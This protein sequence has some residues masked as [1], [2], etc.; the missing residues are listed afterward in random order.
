M[1]LSEMSQRVTSRPSHSAP[2]LRT[3]STVCKPESHGE[4]LPPI[5][6]KLRRVGK[7]IS[8]RR[9]RRIDPRRGCGGGIE[10]TLAGRSELP[11]SGGRTAIPRFEPPRFYQRLSTAE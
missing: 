7:C 8:L 3:S 2:T 9:D 10:F 11:S 6:A 4:T 1:Q 5:D